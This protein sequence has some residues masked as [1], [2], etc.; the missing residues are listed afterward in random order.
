MHAGRDQQ[1]YHQNQQ[2]QR[3]RVRRLCASLQ[4]VEQTLKGGARLEAGRTCAPRINI[5]VSS[6]AIL[7][8]SAPSITASPDLSGEQLFEQPQRRGHRGGANLIARPFAEIVPAHPRPTILRSR[9]HINEA[10]RIAVLVRFGAGDPCDGDHDVS[11]TP[12]KTALR[13]RLR[14]VRADGGVSA[15]SSARTPTAAVLF[16]FVNDE[17]AM[18]D[19]GRALGL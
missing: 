19:I 1:A 3:N 4:L 8:L 14:H 7:S 15:I 9:R 11:G 13:H 18:E 12:R 10:N 2:Q 5:R 6:R 17:A 16:C